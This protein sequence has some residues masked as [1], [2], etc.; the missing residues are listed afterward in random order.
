MD[1]KNLMGLPADQIAEQLM[2]AYPQINPSI[3]VAQ[4][5]Q[6]PAAPAPVPWSNAGDGLPA[7]G[8]HF[9][10]QGMPVQGAQNPTAAMGALMPAFGGG[11]PKA[12]PA[13]MALRGGGSP[14]QVSFPNATPTRRGAPTLGDILGGLK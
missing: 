12:P 4:A 10:N 6:A 9:G 13:P 7:P 14:A 3:F 1:M 8:E 2:K 5:Q 11:A